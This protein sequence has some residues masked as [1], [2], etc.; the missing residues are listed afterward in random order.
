MVDLSVLAS[1]AEAWKKK[2]AKILV[3]ICAIIYAAIIASLAAVVMKLF[4]VKEVAETNER[5]GESSDVAINLTSPA[6][7]QAVGLPARRQDTIILPQTGKEVKN[8]CDTNL[9]NCCGSC[10]FWHGFHLSG[11]G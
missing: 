2:K 5:A 7:L 6:L 4:R 1:V 3:I 9:Q 8:E 11:S 10:A